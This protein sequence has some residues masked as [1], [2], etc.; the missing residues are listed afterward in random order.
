M[1]YTLDYNTADLTFLSCCNGHYLNFVEPFIYFAKKSNP[2]CKIELFVPQPEIFKKQKDVIFHKLPKGR[3]DVLRYI[4][5]PTTNTKHTYICDIDIM[6]TEH[7]Q[8]FHILH[9]EE[10]NLPFSNIYRTNKID[11]LSGLHFVESEKWYAETK[12]ARSKAPIKGQDETIL[13][14][15]TRETYPNAVFSEGLS[16]RPIHG[17]HVSV[18][19][20]IYDIPGWG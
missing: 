9:M 13:H 7:V 4:V 10:T 16:K 14:N 8:P 6:H 12:S 18:G 3:A 20:P 15:I 11:R 5:E 19:R 17:I 2:G 1:R